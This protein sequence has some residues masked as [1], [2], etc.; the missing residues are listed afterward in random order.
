MLL[1]DAG[2]GLYGLQTKTHLSQGQA[3]VAGM[4]RL[5]YQAATI[6]DMDLAWGLDVFRERVGEARFPLVCAN[7]TV[8]ASGELLLPPYAVV[9]LGGRRIAILG[10]TSAERRLEMPEG[11][12]ILAVGDPIAA[13]RQ[14]L[15]ELRRQ[16][17]AVVVLS[18]LGLATNRR[19]AREVRGIAVI[20]GGGSRLAL[21]EPVR[22]PETGT[23]IVEAGMRGESLGRLTVT[24]DSQGV[25]TAYEGQVIELGD[26]VPEDSDM[27]QFL[28]GLRGQ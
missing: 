26:A 21:A 23:L 12:G 18:Q 2:N 1:V 19:L 25:V 15:P 14:Y 6:G 8:V 3:A 5:G 27:K 24:I 20:V 9:A 16:A 10:L 17:D 11:D 4:N 28:E 13:A 7:V 22:V